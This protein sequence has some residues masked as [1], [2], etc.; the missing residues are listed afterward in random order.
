[1][2]GKIFLQLIRLA[3]TAPFVVGLAL[4]MGDDATMTLPVIGST[5][6]SK[7]TL[8]G[9]LGR[10]GM[11]VVY[12]SQQADLGRRVA[13]KVFARQSGDEPDLRRFQRETQI[14]AK[15]GHPNIVSVFDFH[16]GDAVTPPFVVMEL[17]RGKTLGELVR[18]HGRLDAARVARIGL[19]LLEALDAA[20]SN[21]VVHRDCK[22]ANVFCVE[23][24]QGDFVK[25]LDFGVA[26]DLAESRALT[27]PGNIVG[28]LSYMAP[29]QLL[30][31]PAGFSADL[32]SVGACMYFALAGSK[33]F[34]ATSQGELARDILYKDAAPLAALR[35]D[36]IALGAVVHRALAKTPANR[37]ES[38]RA[39]HEAIVAATS[40]S[41]ASTR[42]PPP[43]M[44]SVPTRPGSSLPVPQPEPTRTSAPLAEISAAPRVT[45]SVGAAPPTAP[46]PAPSRIGWFVVVIVL[47]LFTTSLA[48]G[49]GV[50]VYATR[51]TPAPNASADATA[52]IALATPTPSISSLAS[53]SASV[54][55]NTKPVH[56]AVKPP[57]RKTAQPGQCWCIPND[58]NYHLTG[59]LCATVTATRSCGCEGD[60]GDG[61]VVAW[62][63][64][65]LGGVWSCA[66]EQFI[67]DGFANDQSCQGHFLT[68][69]SNDL[70]DVVSTGKLKQ[71]DAC[72]TTD[73]YKGAAGDP[74][75][76]KYRYD[77]SVTLPGHIRC[78]DGN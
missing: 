36:A 5:L 53:A 16:P 65:E 40:A 11:G 24:L 64:S 42:A 70:H 18:A 77:V 44:S 76:G 60:H 49:L 21:G 25:L 66:N 74:C 12:E 35:P 15:L 75:T 2:F 38:A 29:E 47:L 67:G 68:G 9:E 69:P 63:D 41:A 61:C 72:V 34:D 54:S 52:V 1:M 8:L 4:E 58:D 71:C 30:G 59:G 56:P 26:K 6:V 28:T 78:A 62:K 48:T 33:P 10:G 22:P 55:S 37:F 57:P 3:S 20:H 19:Q 43:P 14:L 46:A 17:L 32:Y 13:V 7:Y 23:T 73:V 51:I 31:E 39:M 27:A 50:F 45:Q